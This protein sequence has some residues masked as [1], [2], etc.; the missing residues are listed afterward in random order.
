MKKLYVVMIRLEDYEK[1]DTREKIMFKFREDGTMIG[2][3]TFEQAIE[4]A[5]DIVADIKSDEEWDAYDL[6]ENVETNTYYKVG[7]SYYKTMKVSIVEVV[8]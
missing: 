4:D 7:E 6:P 5:N 8:A 3:E 1:Y 2:H